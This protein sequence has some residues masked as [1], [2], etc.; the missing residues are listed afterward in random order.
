MERR[1]IELKQ[2]IEEAFEDFDYQYYKIDEETEEE[3][4]FDKTIEEL[5]YEYRDIVSVF[6]V[7]EMTTFNSPGYDCGVIMI[8]FVNP[9]TGLETYLEKWE[10]D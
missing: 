6:T 2:K 1:L 3:V 8:A 10:R 9:V 5:F 4:C 7:E